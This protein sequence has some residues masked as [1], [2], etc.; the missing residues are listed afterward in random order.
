MENRKI[1][2]GMEVLIKQIGNAARHPR[3]DEIL[4]GTVTKIGR[5][6]FY[7]CEAH[8]PEHGARPIAFDTM[9]DDRSE[10]HVYLSESDRLEDEETERLRKELTNYFGRM[11]KTSLTLDQ[12]RRIDAI[13]HESERSN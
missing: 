7:V 13:I 4:K 11:Y 1:E 12:L 9:L 8:W 10:W 5:K 6:Y 2:I 3:G